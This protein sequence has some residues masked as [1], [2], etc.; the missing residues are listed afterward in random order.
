VKPWEEVPRLLRILGFKSLA[1]KSDL[2]SSPNTN[3]WVGGISVRGLKIALV[4]EAVETGAWVDI[5]IVD[6]AGLAG[7]LGFH[8]V[9]AMVAIDF[10]SVTDLRKRN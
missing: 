9:L 2:L 5:V 3:I 7:R 6:I 4:F 10:M 1:S 8:G